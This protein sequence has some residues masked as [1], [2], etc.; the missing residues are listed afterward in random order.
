[1][2]A[3]PDVIVGVPIC[4]STSFVLNKFLCNQEEIRKA[5]PDCSLAFATDEPDFI[6]ELEEQIKMHDL[7]G[8]VIAYETV[9]PA[10]ARTRLWSI[11][12]GREMLR[13]YALS[14]NVEYLL[15]LDGDMVFEPA[16]VDIMKDK[17]KDFDVVFSGYLMP[18]GGFWGFGTGC[19]MISRKI[20]GK[21][22]FRCY[23]FT[24]GQI[25]D[26]SETLDCVYLSV[27]Q[28]STRA[29][30]SQSSII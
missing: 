12:Y 4:R 9:K 2:S 20:L 3:R 14:M 29:S 5:Y 15:F 26:E 18:P 13:R 7:K 16:V 19:L 21:I 17:I 30:L 8:R 23:E 6:T 25:I 10:Y 27:V 11:T 24:N 1:M 22:I 28:R